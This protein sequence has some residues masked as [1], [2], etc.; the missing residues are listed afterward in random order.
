MLRGAARRRPGLYRRPDG[1]NSSFTAGLP[2]RGMTPSADRGGG[3]RRLRFSREGLGDYCGR[4][5][6][7]EA[8]QKGC[9]PGWRGTNLGTV[10]TRRSPRDGRKGRN[11]GFRVLSVVKR[12]CGHGAGLGQVSPC[13]ERRVEI[14]AD[15]IDDDPGRSCIMTDGATGS[16]VRQCHPG[17]ATCHYRSTHRSPPAAVSCPPRLTSIVVACGPA[18]RDM[19]GS[20]CAHRL[21]VSAWPR[22]TSGFEA[23]SAPNA[24][25]GQDALATLPYRALVTRMICY[26]GPN[27]DLYLTAICAFE[28]VAQILLQEYCF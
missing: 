23:V 11:A 6:S 7:C 26:C 5:M 24:P 12:V 17:S 18:P 9:K 22:P 14:N 27:Q 25:P 13:R 20:T 4:R 8:G 21:S 3:W 10:G 15:I 16:N 2:S 1:C 28:H 19:L